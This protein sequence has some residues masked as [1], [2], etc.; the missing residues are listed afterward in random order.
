MSTRVTVA[1]LPDCDLCKMDPVRKN[2]IA[3]YDGVLWTGPW[4][5]M[6]E[7]HFKLRGVGLGLGRGQE[8]VVAE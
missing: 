5:Y 4:A 2:A 7:F 3:K 8:L 1:K 6:C